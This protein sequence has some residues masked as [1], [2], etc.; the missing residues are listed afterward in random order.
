[1]D[2]FYIINKDSN[3]KGIKEIRIQPLF[4]NTAIW[5]MNSKNGEDG[6]VTFQEKR[7][8]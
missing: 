2:R 4:G 3:W 5:K 8:C 7:R 6:V 1:M